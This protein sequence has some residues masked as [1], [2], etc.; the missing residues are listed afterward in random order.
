MTA[1]CDDEIFD[2]V[3]DGDNVIG[4]STRGKVH[5]TGLLHRAVHVFVLAADGRIFLQ[6]RSMQ[7]DTAPGKWDSSASGH[8][9]AGES[10]DAAASRELTE[11]LG[12]AAPPVPQL[13]FKVSAC[14]DTGN[15]FV[16]AYRIAHDGPFAL[17]PDEISGGGWF[18]LDE[19]DAW[20]A[21]APMDFA[22]S[23]CYLWN[24]WR[25]DS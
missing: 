21:R 1:Q 10:Y 15:E 19:V 13:L 23:F 18:S 6:K 24:I 11:E 3:D 17:H 5:R 16:Q 9:D 4:Q 20:V 12:I 2:I 25:A 8:L 7:K 22:R 14:E